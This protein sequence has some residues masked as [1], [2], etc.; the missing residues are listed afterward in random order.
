MSLIRQ[1]SRRAV[2]LQNTDSEVATS[3]TV[4]PYFEW[5]F[6]GELNVPIETALDTLHHI[7]AEN[8]IY[9]VKVSARQA[10]DST[11]RFKVLSYDI[12]GGD[13]ITHVNR[14]ATFNT[15]RETLSLVIDDAFIG[16]NRVIEVR[17][18]EEVVGV[19]P[20]KDVTLSIT[21]GSLFEVVSQTD[22][23]VQRADDTILPRR[24]KLQ[25]IGALIEDDLPNDRTVVTIGSVGDIV[26]S[27]LTEAQF[28]SLRGM[29]WVLMDGRSVVGSAYETIT[30]ETN[31]P[32]ARGTYLRTKDNGR[33]L[34][35]NGDPALGSYQDDELASHQHTTPVGAFS[36]QVN[37]NPGG[38][39]S[40]FEN[41]SVT[42]LTGG[43]ETRPKT[44][45]VNTFI[46]I[47]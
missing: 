13:Q 8:T 15:D 29:D 19:V 17:L 33:G 45:I 28:Q 25:V 4:T 10:G 16:E 6:N 43:N 42:G 40:D 26:Q 18:F 34:D 7:D 36:G 1:I 14:L 11:Y 24:T 38:D 41:G 22:F 2:V 32:D 44:T 21:L 47:N 3:K 20:A 23:L 9:Q 30:G 35:P 5:V 12:N 31:I 39:E 46:K 27:M 37:D